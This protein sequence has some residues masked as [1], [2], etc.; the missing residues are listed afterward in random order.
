[1]L[2]RIFFCLL[3]SSK[4]HYS[5]VMFLLGKQKSGKS[6]RHIA[7]NLTLL[8]YPEAGHVLTLRYRLAD[9][10]PTFGWHCANIW[11]TLRRHL[12]DIA[13]TFGWHCANVWLTLRQRLADISDKSTRQCA[14]HVAYNVLDFASYVLCL[15]LL[16][17]VS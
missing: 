5:F 10:A 6:Q 16:V 17:T 13:P 2:V 1:M 4:E 7:A 14:M 9:I 3:W 15:L 8:W 12:A 11:L